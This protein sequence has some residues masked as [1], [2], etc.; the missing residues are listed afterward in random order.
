MQYNR[1]IKQLAP[2]PSGPLPT[3]KE[4]QGL[5]RQ[6]RYRQATALNSFLKRVFRK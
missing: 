4:L 6:S 5:I 3:E 1:D 2:W